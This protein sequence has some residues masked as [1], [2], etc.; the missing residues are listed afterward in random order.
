MS[1]PSEMAATSHQPTTPSTNYGAYQTEIYKQGADSGLV[2]IVT[3]NPV[4][5]ENQAKQ[6]LDPRA[7]SF[8]AGGAGEKATME[9]NRLAFRRRKLVMK[10]MD[11]QSLET[12]L[13]GTTYPTPLIVAPMG[14]QSLMHADKETG[15][16][17]VCGELGIPYTLSTASSASIE[18]VADT[19]GPGN[20]RWFQ[21]YWT[22]DE[23]I[24]LSL[25]DRAK[26]TGYDVLVVSLD[27][28]TLG[29]RPEI[30]DHG[31]F[32][33]LMG[34]GNDVGFTDP[35]FRAKFEKVT[36]VSVEDDVM[37]AAKAWVAELDDRPH[38]WAQVEFLRRHWEGPIVLKGIQHVDDARR[39]VETGCQGIVVSNHGGRQVDG[40]IG[41]LDVLPEIVDAVGDKVTVMFDSGVRTGADVMK[42]LC[43]GAKAVL[44]GRPVLYGLAVNGK[45]GA[46]AV[47]QGLLAEL[48]Q[49]M[50]LAGMETVAD[51]RRECLRT[52]KYPG[53]LKSKL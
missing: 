26:R 25:M 28:W 33:W 36:G 3:T 42:A 53:E 46:R 2:P 39:A 44:V 48:W 24:L 9:A 37:G 51:C 6:V 32:P 29:W 50:G 19:N 22:H 16:A 13:F 35:V 38:T 7:Y 18:D 41:A 45:L 27:T 4:C 1:S 43:L 34:V 21:L 5:L 49:T 52:V 23:E 14:A 12:S 30:L 31:Y 40:A 17:E 47:L 8:V 10:P 11:K 15:V 20:P